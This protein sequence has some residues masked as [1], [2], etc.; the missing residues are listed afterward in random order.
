MK[1]LADNKLQN[2]IRGV[3]QRERN[4]IVIILGLY[5]W[6]VADGERKGNSIDLLRISENEKDQELSSTSMNS[7]VNQLY[8]YTDVSIPL[9]FWVQR[10]EGKS[11]LRLNENK[12]SDYLGFPPPECKPAESST[13]LYL[14][15]RRYYDQ[16]MYNIMK[17]ETEALEIPTELNNNP[18]WEDE[19]T[20]Q[21][22]EFIWKEEE[23]TRGSQQQ[24]ST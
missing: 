2:A 3:R 4:H 5:G 22:K 8:S 11:T 7:L 10:R 14:Y 21:E 1:P 20:Q 16:R 15:I 18:Q 12:K 19:I 24:K 13:S 23:K 6:K 17:H 9:R